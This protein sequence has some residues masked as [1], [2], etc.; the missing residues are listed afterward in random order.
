MTNWS[1]WTLYTGSTRGVISSVLPSTNLASP[2]RTGT[3][4]RS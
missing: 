4:L 1:A 2:S 3:R